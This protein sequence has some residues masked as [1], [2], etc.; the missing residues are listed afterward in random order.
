MNVCFHMF[1]F[2]K[3]VYSNAFLVSKYCCVVFV[4]YIYF[5]VSITTTKYKILEILRCIVCDREYRRYSK[6][7]IRIYNKTVSI[8]HTV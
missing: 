5:D 4:V 1:S 2:E 8:R 6:Q 3:F 7:R